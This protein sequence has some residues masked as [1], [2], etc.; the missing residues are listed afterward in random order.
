M[1]DQIEMNI[2]LKC[3]RCM[4]YLLYRNFQSVEKEVPLKTLNHS[5]GN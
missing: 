1:K 3:Q 2:L 5:T 4:L